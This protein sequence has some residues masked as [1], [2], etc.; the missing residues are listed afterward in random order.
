MKKSS[1]GVILFLGVIVFIY[2]FFFRLS[3]QEKIDNYAL[4]NNFVEL[5]DLYSKLEVQ[6][7]K[8][9]LIMKTEESYKNYVL[10]NYEKANFDSVESFISKEIELLSLLK[11]IPF[12]ED[13][14]I[15]KS[16]SILEN[17]NDLKDEYDSLDSLK[18][19]KIENMSDVN[20]YELYIIYR[21]KSSNHMEVAGKSISKEY[22][23]CYYAEFLEYNQYLR[24]YQPDGIN[25]F[26]IESTS[27]LPQGGVQG[28]F[29]KN[30]TYDVIENGGFEATYDKLEC[31]YNSDM[32][33]YYAWEAAQIKKENL[34]EIINSKLMNWIKI[35]KNE[36]DIQN[37]QIIDIKKYVGSWY[38]TETGEPV[39][40]DDGYVEKSGTSIEILETIP[41]KYEISVTSLF[42]SGEMPGTEYLELDVQGDTATASYNED[43]WGNRGTIKLNFVKDSMYITISSTG[44]GD[45]NLSMDNMHC[46]KI[47]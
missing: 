20:F 4:E 44:G 10:S 45:F 6:E 34:Y 25:G 13:N 22:T 37:S 40:S 8:D 3:D 2:L 43:G 12:T 33:Q 39:F 47:K 27:A 29:I 14:F 28:H 11:K 19:G 16:Y 24:S 31:I 1:M 26:I 35:A 42:D 15:S 23:D 5:V 41:N 17:C 18:K 46:T 30:G 38:V 36:K 9:Y 7:E 21:V 32:D